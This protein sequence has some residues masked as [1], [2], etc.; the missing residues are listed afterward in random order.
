M[1]ASSFIVEASGKTVN[2]AFA[3]ATE[4]A[5]YERG[6]GGYTGTIAEKNAFTL[7]TI[8]AS[9]TPAREQDRTDERRPAA[10]ADHLI[11]ED[12]DRVCNKWGPAGA[13]DLGGEKWL[14]FGWAS[15]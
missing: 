10:Y 7:I 13:I 2:A 6:H 5:R 1:G 12:D 14:F 9:Y 8:P 4:Q 3:R 15:R 11:N